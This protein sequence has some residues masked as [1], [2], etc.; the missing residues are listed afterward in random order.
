MQIPGFIGPS[1]PSQSSFVAGERCINWIPE[2]I[3][4]GNKSRWTLFSCP[5]FTNFATG[6]SVPGRGIFGENG[7]LF[8]V[9]GNRLYEI[10][11]TGTETE[12]GSVASSI[13]PVSWATNG[14][15]DTGGDELLVVSGDEG[16][17]LTLS[18]NTLTNPVSDITMCGQIGGFFVGLDADT[19]TMK[20]SDALDG[21]T[22]DVTQ[23]VQRTSASD[24][25]TSMLVLRNEI[26]L[27]GE[28]TGEVWYN[29]GTSPFPFLQ[30][31]GAFWEIGNIAPFSLSRLGNSLAWLGGSAQGVGIVYLMNGYTPNR[32]S[33]HAVEWAINEYRQNSTITDAIGWSYEKLGHIFYVLEF[34]TAGKT[35]VYD[36]VTDQWHER[37]K[38]SSVDG[39]FLAYRAR[40]HMPF[41]GRNLVCDSAGG[42]VYELS[43]TVYR[44]V[45][46][47][48]LRRVRRTPHTFGE[49]RRVRLDYIEV[50]AERG[51]GLT[52]GQGSDPKLM[53]RVSKNGGATWGNERFGSLG[54][55]GEYGRRCRFNRFGSGRDFVFEVSVSDPVAA[56]LFDAYM[57]A[58]PLAH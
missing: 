6:L 10:D 43:H 12:L 47:D 7:R 13:D 5:G 27:F 11:S 1:Y 36:V 26:F 50:E 56:N 57:G 14:D 28:K 42:T 18:T 24:P 22:W 58:T 51:V 16:Y 39:D 49:H 32:I 9:F 19:G 52:S 23:V 37:G 20:I 55:K 30:R 4:D 29:A 31:N 2:R 17:L 54:K 46:G 41:F 15:A 48:E 33:N 45:G 25:W 8:A 3:P 35:W 21:T 38:W 40:F 53:L 34:P 44:D